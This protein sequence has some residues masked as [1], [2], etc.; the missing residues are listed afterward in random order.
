MPSR[1]PTAA[2]SAVALFGVER[3]RDVPAL[4]HALGMRPA[5]VANAVSD[6]PHPGKLVEPAVRGGHARGDG[7]GVIGDMHRGRD[8]ALRER[9]GQL[10]RQPHALHLRQIGRFLDHARAHEARNGYADRVD[11]TRIAR[12][13][14]AGVRFPRVNL[15]SVC[16]A[17]S[18]FAARQACD[19][20]GEK[21][22]QFAVGNRLQRF[23]RIRVAGIAQHLSGQPQLLQPCRRD[24]VCDD[25]A[26]RRCHNTL[27]GKS[28]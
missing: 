12:I 1:C 8:A 26:D 27:Q 23:H 5:P 21:I 19:L 6:G 11:S 14:F 13:G 2:A 24:V 9:R 10:F 7:V 3:H 15:A 20:P 4:P 16:L 25:D 28:G 17:R 22:N 18:G